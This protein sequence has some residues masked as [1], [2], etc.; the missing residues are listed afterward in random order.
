MTLPV[1]AGAAIMATPARLLRPATQTAAGETSVEETT[2]EAVV[3]LAAMTAAGAVT[4]VE[5]ISEV[6]VIL[7]EVVTL[8]VAEAILAAAGIS[9]PVP[10]IE[11]VVHATFVAG[12]G[13][14]DH[15]DTE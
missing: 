5:A 4:L 12:A 7:V 8:V 9:N 3:I 13:L 15:G 14:D 10:E 11:R 1:R 2:P 6:A